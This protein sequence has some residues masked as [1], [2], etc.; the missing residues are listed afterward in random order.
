MTKIECPVCKCEKFYI[1]DKDDPYET[2]ELVCKEGHL[3][4]ADDEAVEGSIAMD[5]QS[6][7]FCDR[8]AWHGAESQLKA[9]KASAD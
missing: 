1:K 7:V 4:L 3:V 9:P 2:Y 5:G 6:E 8:C